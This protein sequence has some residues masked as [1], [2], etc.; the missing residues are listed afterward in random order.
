VPGRHRLVVRPPAEEIDERGAGADQWRDRLLVGLRRRGGDALPVPLVEGGD[1][2]RKT[3]SV[4]VP[5]AD[6]GLERREDLAHLVD[7]EL[8][9]RLDRVAGALD[10][11][12]RAAPGKCV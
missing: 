2:M 6:R 5:E 7:A 11:G 1:P 12:E 9:A 8:P 4:E 3:A 10:G